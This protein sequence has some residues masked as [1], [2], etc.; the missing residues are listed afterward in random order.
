MSFD[1]IKTWAE[2]LVIK[3]SVALEFVAAARRDEKRRGAESLFHLCLH[4]PTN[5]SK[6]NLIS[7]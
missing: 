1:V 3:I 7:G 2:E 6:E 4:S 5:E